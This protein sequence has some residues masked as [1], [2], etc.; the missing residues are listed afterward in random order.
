VSAVNPVSPVIDAVRMEWVR[1]STIRS[2]VVLLGLALLLPAAIALLV[3]LNAEPPLD[4]SQVVA[5]LTA[6]S[7]FTPLPLPAVFA[8]V[9][10]VL[11]VGH[12]YE[13]GTGRAVLTAVPR[14]SALLTG[15]LGLLAVAVAVAGVVSLAVDAVVLALTLP[16]GYSLD[17]AVGALAG[18]VLL[19]VLWSLAGAG[20]AL[21]LRATTGPIVVLLVWPL[22]VEPLLS[23]LLSSDRLKALNPV[24][25]YL[26]FQAGRQLAVPEVLAAAPGEQETLTQLQGGLVFT[27]FTAALVALGWLAYERRDA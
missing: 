16:S 9:L 13:H 19:L 4:A 12:D 17:G 2:T 18:Y 15:R 10:G 27:L 23:V 8:G 21:L 22:I 11:S 25:R 24:A 7:G 1:L 14:R 26:P 6:G 20:L 5:G 3:G